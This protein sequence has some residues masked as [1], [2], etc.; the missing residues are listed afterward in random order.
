MEER[1]VDA[2]LREASYLAD[3]IE[4]QIDLLLNLVKGR[5]HY[6]QPS[7]TSNLSQSRL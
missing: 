5:K 1:D 2:K 4:I 3:R 7:S 6:E